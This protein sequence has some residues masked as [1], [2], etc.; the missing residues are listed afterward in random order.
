MLASRRKLGE[1]L[2]PN[3]LAITLVTDNMSLP[4]NGHELSVG[5]S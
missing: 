4:R 1:G 5:D 2:D 3:P